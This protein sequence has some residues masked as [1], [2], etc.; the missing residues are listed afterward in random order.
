MPLR[1][2]LYCPD[3]HLTYDGRTPDEVGVGGGVT[4]RVRMAR[5][6]ARLGHDVTQVVNCT[7]RETIDGVDYR[8]LDDP[9]RLQA[10]VAVFN[11]SGG[12]L[13]LSPALDLDLAAR[14][15]IVWVHGT[16]PTE[17][18]ARMEYDTVY[19]V[20]NFLGRIVVDT[21]EVPAE[22]L[23]VTYNGYEP[24][25]FAA[26]EADAPERDPFQLIYFSHPSKGL[27]T[28]LSILSELRRAEPRFHLEVAGGAR[29]WG[30]AEAALIQ[31]D[32]VRDHGLLGQR[33]LVPLLLRSTYA[34]QMQDREEPFGFSVIEAMRAG[35]VVVASPAGALAE[36][37]A[38]GVDG[39][40]VS[41]DHREP[42]TR[43]AAVEAIL[44]L[45]EDP[46]SR[47]AIVCRARVAASDTD[48][49]A[50]AWVEDW[51][52]R[53]GEAEPVS[54]AC[55]RCGGLAHRL[56]DGDH[57]T[58]CGRFTPFGIPEAGR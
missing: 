28:T 44:R 49:L 51:R 10:D 17:G 52:A 21:W 39:V 35:L 9:G 27:E 56:A 26:A 6:L 25:H 24:S 55:S 13:D 8:P 22:T 30:G 18:L 5:A 43:Q 23:F 45:H 2:V 15:R 31:A 11:T 33:A 47:A 1:V 7:R 37:I 54:T 38:D 40:I 4:S 19:A 48:T 53:L 58:A 14:L 57:C 32:G 20:S 29:L 16:Q 46:E 34:I 50:R 41:G 42:S 3:R 36:L 12:A